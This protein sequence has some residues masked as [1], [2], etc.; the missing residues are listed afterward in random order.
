LTLIEGFTIEGGS[1]TLVFFEGTG[2]GGILCIGSS[3]TIRGCRIRGNSATTSGGGILAIDGAQMTVADCLIEGNEA[4]L[5]GGVAVH[6]D[7]PEVRT[8]ITLR[9]TR[10]LLN[11]SLIGGGASCLDAAVLDVEGCTFTG[12]EALVLGGGLAYEDGT[13]S[14]AGSSFLDNRAEDGGGF[15]AGAGL[16]RFVNCLIAGNAAYNGGGAMFEPTP[17]VYFEDSSTLLFNCTI[18]DNSAIESASGGIYFL[19]PEGDLVNSIVW[20]NEGGSLYADGGMGRFT[21]CQ[22]EGPEPPE[23][24][25]NSNQDPLF[26]AKGRWNNGGTDDDPFDDRWQAGDYH[27]AAGSPA[28][29]AGTAHGAPALDLEGRSRPCGAG[30]DVGAYESGGCETG[31]ARFRRGDAN[32]DRVLDLADAI[33]TLDALFRGGPPPP[34]ADA[35]DAD[36][37]GRWNLTDP[38]F[39]LGHLFRGGPSPPAPEACGGDPTADG[40]GCTGGETNC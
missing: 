9:N 8:A 17:G 31:G 10:L 30:I 25:G 13:V 24:E 4:D 40:L 33:Y 16:G 28:I 36:D 26:V 27:L 18:A 11:Q 5:G 35:A 15:Y 22:V 1:G 23:G 29:D 19:E 34:C 14:V 3:P 20:G 7:T 6:G 2:G 39:T 21:H 12:N 37:N 38:I 32:A